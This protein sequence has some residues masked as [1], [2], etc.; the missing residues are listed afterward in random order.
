MGITFTAPKMQFQR[1]SGRLDKALLFAIAEGRWSVFSK[2]ARNAYDKTLIAGFA[3]PLEAQE[4]IAEADDKRYQLDQIRQGYFGFHDMDRDSRGNFNGSVVKPT[5]TKAA[6]PGCLRDKLP[7]GRITLVGEQ[8]ATMIRVVPHISRDM[9]KE[10]MFE[11]FVISL[12]KE[13]SGQKSK[14][15][16]A[17]F[18]ERLEAFKGS[19]Q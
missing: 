2:R 4:T 14:E 10:D 17:R 19:T 11:W 8:D 3:L 12:D 16:M 6:Y 15:R 5:Y 18:T 7:K 9:I 13:V 1:P